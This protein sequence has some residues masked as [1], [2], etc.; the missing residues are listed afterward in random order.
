MNSFS[1]IDVIHTLS[2]GDFEETCREH[3]DHVYLGDDV[4]L[5][6][7]LTKYKMYVNT[8]D[9]G[10][11]PHLMLEGYWE[12]WLTQL[13]AKIIRPG[14]VCLDVG[15]NFGY[16]SLIMSELCGPEG[17]TIAF[18]PNPH[19]CELLRYT[20]FLHGW[21]FDVMQA[22]LSDKKGEATLTVTERHF[23][24]AT[25]KP[26]ELIPG[27]S[28]ITVPTLSVDELVKEKDLERVDVI[29][30]DVEGVEPLVF[31]GMHETISNNPNIHIIMEYSPSIYDDAQKFTDYL[32]SEF[33]V[34][35]VKDV[36]EV[37]RL[38]KSSIPSLVQMPDHTDLYLRPK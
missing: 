23:G 7:V 34:Y 5:C 27:R 4:V 22:A 14:F 30:M 37:T 13:L 26:N 11:A 10:I 24:G 17:K 12:S 20:E 1:S 32:F 6:R 33:T 31:A 35:R 3:V 38:D 2:R 18:E 25:I 8:K 19:I 16:Y 21:N 36:A 28:Q 9:L 15:A 29:K